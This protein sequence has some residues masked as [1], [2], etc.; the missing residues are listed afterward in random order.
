MDISVAE[1]SFLNGKSQFEQWKA[2]FLAA[3]YQPVTDQ[4][5]LMVVK[6]IM[7]MPPEV[8]EQMSQMQP[9]AWKNIQKVARDNKLEV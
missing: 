5:F 2:K 9:A 7:S 8:K 3:W 4:M 6:Q 1:S